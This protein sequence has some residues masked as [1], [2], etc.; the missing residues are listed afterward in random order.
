[1]PPDANA[2]EAANTIASSIA[3]LEDNHP[4]AVKIILGDFNHCTLEN[5]LPSYTQ[6]VSC[7]TRENNKLDLCYANIG[8]AF[9]CHCP[10]GQSDHNIIHMVPTYKT[11]FKRSK[12]V[13]RLV[14]QWTPD[15]LEELRACYDCT[16]WDV[17]CDGNLEQNTD[18][19]SAYLI[20]CQDMIIP[21]KEVKCFPNNKPWVTKDLKQI[22]NEKKAAL[23]RKNKD[24]LKRIQTKLDT[25]IRSCRSSFK[26]KLEDKFRSH[27]S[28]DVWKGLRQATGFGLKSQNLDTAD[29]SFTNDLNKFY[30]RFDKYDF[31]QQRDMMERELQTQPDG[32]LPVTISDASV[33]KCLKQVKP[34]KAVGPDNISG[35]LLKECSDQLV[36]VLQKLFQESINK[37]SVPTLWKSSEIIPVPKKPQPAVM[38]DYR[39][40]ALTSIIMKCLERVVLT[41]LLPSVK[42]LMDPLQFAYRAKRGVEDATLTL[43]HHLYQHLDTA[44][45]VARVLMVDFSSAFNTIQPHLMMNKLMSMGVNNHIILWVND[46]LLHRPQRVRIGTV[47]SDTTITNTGAPQG[48]VLSPVLFTLYTNDCRSSS[49]N[50]D[51]IKYA[52]DSAIIGRLQR[53]HAGFDNYNTCVEQFVNW[54]SSNYL[55]LNVSKTKELIFDFSKTNTVVTPIIINEEHVSIVDEYKYLGLL[56]DNK[57][58][59]SSN[60][61]RVFAKMQ[62]RLYFLRK[63]NDFHVDTRIMVLFYRSVVESVLR[64]CLQ[65]FYNNSLAKDVGKLSRVTN[66][67]TKLMKHKC[68]P[69]SDIYDNLCAEKLS[70]ILQDD[71]HPLH[72][73]YNRL[74][75]GVRLESIRC[76]TSRYLKSFVPKSIQMYNKKCIR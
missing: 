75:S 31:S 23:C 25:N 49:P 6:Y 13:T 65:V 59:W 4:D 52:D 30:S 62:Q 37:H 58:N 44:G 36:P 28:K 43:V 42:P 24:D 8:D 66:R 48:C 71:T 47:C 35:R 50:C 1:M 64:F 12:P 54:C 60:N 18:V 17:L 3:M 33:R 40:V 15:S 19:I 76:K 38:N 57:L 7:A 20:F 61:K 26:T 51:I 53:G 67:A 41:L 46:F 32:W 22:I 72:G 68:S 39:P 70:S 74:R 5:V 2:T 16:Q 29:E 9:L 63:L 55:E 14:K 45:N 11:Q 10:L 21:Q 73:Y 69:P 27:N 34:N 56:V